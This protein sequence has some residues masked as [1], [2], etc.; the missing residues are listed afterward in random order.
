MASQQRPDS[1]PEQILKSTRCRT[2]PIIADTYGGRSRAK[3][4]TTNSRQNLRCLASPLRKS[5]VDGAA[6]AVDKN[7][8]DVLDALVKPAATGLPAQGVRQPS[9]VVAG[10][11][12]QVRQLV[13]SSPGKASVRRER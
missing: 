6:S 12:E 11:P 2:D 9:R 10:M 5:Q 8:R 3:E 13:E 1:Q 4:R 7:R